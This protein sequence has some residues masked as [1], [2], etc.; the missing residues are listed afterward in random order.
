MSQV[1]QPFFQMQEQGRTG[2]PSDYIFQLNSEE[3]NIWFF[4]RS[5]LE[6]VSIVI[7]SIYLITLLWLIQNKLTSLGG[8]E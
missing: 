2:N 1:A 8:F 3:H 7:F 6:T 4:L 5:S